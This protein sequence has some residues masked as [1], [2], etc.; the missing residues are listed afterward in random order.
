MGS[1]DTA[2]TKQKKLK[3]SKEKWTT[4]WLSGHTQKKKT[5]EK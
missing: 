5:G 1:V 4:D 2:A 3:E